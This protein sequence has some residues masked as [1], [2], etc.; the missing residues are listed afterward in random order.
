MQRGHAPW[1]VAAAAGAVL[2]LGW[3]FGPRPR[4]REALAEPVGAGA[5]VVNL[6]RLEGVASCASTACHGGNGPPGSWRSEYTTWA[7]CDPH[8]RAYTVLFGDLSRRIQENLNRGE[9]DPA[10]DFSAQNNPLCLKCHATD[11]D[12]HPVA[13]GFTLVDGVG[14]ES[15]HGAAGEWLAQHYRLPWK[16]MSPEAK[17]KLGFTFTKDLQVRAEV[18]VRCHVGS[19]DTTGLPVEVNHDLIAAG[20]PRLRFEFGA[21]LANY[22]KHW[23]V[24]EDEKRYPDL[25]AR[26][27]MIGQVASAR[28]A[29]HLLQADAAAAKSSAVVWPEFAD[30][31]CYS[32]HHDL[33]SPSWRQQE[34]KPGRLG[35]MRRNPWYTSLAELLV[36]PEAAAPSTRLDELMRRPVPDRAAVARAAGEAV[37]A[38]GVLKVPPQ[39]AAEVR[40][41]LLSVV[42]DGGKRAV[43]N[44]DAAVQFYLAVAALYHSLSDFHKTDPG[45]KGAVQALGRDLNEA[46]WSPP[47]TQPRV[48]YDS[49]R[50]LDRDE[51]LKKIQDLR[52][53][54]GLE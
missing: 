9:Q 46:F 25:Q 24:H 2:L 31:D 16:D 8:S 54:L 41:L 23:S 11:P 26:A 49:P 28:A 27:W 15:C 10:K 50:S 40:G 21:Y 13:H 44:P 20:H 53:Q 17:A 32:C 51:L 38:F 4:N 3:G 48:H 37:A 45:L 47:G 22:P 14:C 18:C 39:K 34:E 1:I 29:L 7:M 5:A 52:A 19:V 42:R 12:H 30:F 35:Q 6:S 33:T 36:T 43:S